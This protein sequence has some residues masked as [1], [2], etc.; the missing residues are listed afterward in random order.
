MFKKADVHADG[1]QRG[2]VIFVKNKGCI[3]SHR[4]LSANTC[5]VMRVEQIQLGGLTVRFLN[6]SNQN[7]KGD[8]SYSH[9]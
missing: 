9:I 5:S 7:I 1:G 4:E 2:G 3:M 8:G 6:V